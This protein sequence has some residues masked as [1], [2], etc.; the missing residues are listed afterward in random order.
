MHKPIRIGEVYT[1]LIHFSKADV[2]K[3]AEA[4]GDTNPLHTDPEYCKETRFGR[5]I[6]QGALLFSHFSR[7]FGTIWPGEGS[8]YVSQTLKFIAPVYVGESANL[9]IKCV[10]VDK[11]KKKATFECSLFAANNTPV[12]TGTAVLWLPKF[13]L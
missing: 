3:F 8:V 4:S 2:E 6:V 1:E 9:E 7:V 13:D 11:E 10:E 5:P 12:C